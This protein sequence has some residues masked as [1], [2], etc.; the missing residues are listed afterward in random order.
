MSS[1]DSL[2]SKTGRDAA[3]IIA[4]GLAMAAFAIAMTFNVRVMISTAFEQLARTRD[5]Q[6]GVAS[7]L[8]NVVD[9]ETGYR[10]FL[11]TRDTEFL[12]P[13]E[14]SSVAAPVAIANLRKLASEEEDLRDDIMRFSQAANS[15]M[16]TMVEQV[17][18]WKENKSDPRTG[19]GRISAIKSDVDALRAMAANLQLRLTAQLS[20]RRQGVSFATSRLLFSVS[21]LILGL[22]LIVFA[23]ARNLVLQTAHHDQRHDQSSR[24]I[25]GLTDTVSRAEA[26]LAASHRQ[27]ELALRSAKVQVFTLRSDGVVDWVSD[28]KSAL[29]R[30][31]TAPFSLADL[32]EEKD[33]ATVADRIEKS[34]VSGEPTEFELR[35]SS[36]DG[37]REWVKT[38]LDPSAGGEAAALGVA[39][40]ITGLR[41]REERMFWLMRELSHRSKNLL[42]IVQ[43]IARQT[44]RSVSSIEA[45]EKRFQARMRG[46]AAA[47]DLLVKSSYEGADLAEIIASQLGALDH[48]VGSRIF[49]HGP[50]VFIRHE[51]AQNIAMAF[52]ELFSNA[53]AHGA[54]STGKGRVAIDWR[55]ADEASGSRLLIDWV[56]SEGPPPDMASSKGFGTSIIAVNLPRSLDGDV[57]LERR[58]DGVVCHMALP[59]RRLQ[60]EAASGRA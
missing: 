50:S 16:D 24:A 47:H 1:T 27:L 29:A 48:F 18:Q 10:G 12:S 33:R 41:E 25:A 45:F 59:M 38:T 57:T 6:L 4:L 35:L 15:L 30:M 40:D 53:E 20:D 19:I 28:G 14:S 2:K 54:L 5:A 9:A 60:P 13:Y 49:L 3:I 46:L 42:A 21:I 23:L 56:E 8:S 17:S 52:Q 36:G 7:A 32:A 39:V 22:G 58:A 31:R 44:A 43:A 34:F 55:V 26:K 51:A 37:G 11:L